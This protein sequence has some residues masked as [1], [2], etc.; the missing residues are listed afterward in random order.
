MLILTRNIRDTRM[1]HGRAGIQAARAPKLG[2]P[3][4]SRNP[5]VVAKT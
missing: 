2:H 5:M 1:A 3:V 4:M